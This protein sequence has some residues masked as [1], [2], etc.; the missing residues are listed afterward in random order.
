MTEPTAMSRS[1][2]L[3]RIRRPSGQSHRPGH[4]V[5]WHTRQ[6]AGVRGF[7]SVLA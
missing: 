4:E 1:S 2:P 7:P 3:D 5:H 6:V